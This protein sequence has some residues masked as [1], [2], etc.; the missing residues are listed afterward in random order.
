LSSI[1]IACA[2]LPCVFAAARSAAPG[3]SITIRSIPSGRIES[4]MIPFGSTRPRMMLQK[5]CSIV[6][7]SACSVAVIWPFFSASSKSKW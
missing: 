3:S 6:A 2:S 1:P 5:F 7:L 4:S